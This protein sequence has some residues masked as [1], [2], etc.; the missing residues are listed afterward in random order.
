MKIGVLTYHYACNFGANLQVLSTVGY[1]RRMGH[2]PVVID[3]RSEAVEAQYRRNTPEPQGKVHER[4]AAAHL[5]VSAPC[6]TA[7]EIAE[8]IAREGIEAVIVGSDAVVTVSPR[9][10]RLNFSGRKL[11]FILSR[12]PDVHEL[13]NP[14][15]GSF[16]AH[17]GGDVPCAMM[18][19]SSQNTRFR[20]LSPGQR[21][22]AS[23]AL[24]RLSYVSVRDSWTRQM[25]ASA[26]GGAFAPEVTPDPVFSFNR[27]VPPELISGDVIA[28]FRLPE[29]YFLVSFKGEHS[30]PEQWVRDFEALAAAQ[31][32]ACVALPYPQGLS[33]MGLGRRIEL[34]LDPLQWYALIKYSSGYV[35]HNMHPIVSCIHNAVPF[36]SFDNYGFLTLKLFGNSKSSKIYDLLAGA[37]MLDHRSGCI[38]RFPTYPPPADVL[39]RLTG[40]DRGACERAAA[41]KLERY[42]RMMES[43]L[44]SFGARTVARVSA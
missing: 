10:D 27:N 43:I 3:W 39:A 33:A 37:G 24:R 14:F 17:P 42:D 13:P 25:M 19:V 40:F 4:F 18:S 32:F 34:P 36:H 20:L 21:R 7:P 28:P 6:R 44:A 15:W 16:L 5:P 29:K 1:L 12:P 41:V 31:G 8:V 2:T 38:G 9:F 23:E 30:P 11:R 22:H 26:T 35:G